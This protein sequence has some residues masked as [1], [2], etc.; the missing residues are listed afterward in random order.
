MPTRSAGGTWAGR[1]DAVAGGDLQALADGNVGLPLL[2]HV[3]DV[4]LGPA[5]PD[6]REAKGEID[7]AI[8]EK[9]S[10]RSEP[11]SPS[12][13]TAPAACASVCPYAHT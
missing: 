12:S 6:G 1:A 13:P 11:P 5:G 7:G 10:A 8:E 9:A 2:L 4:P 3:V